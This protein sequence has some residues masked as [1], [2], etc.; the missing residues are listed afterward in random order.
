MQTLDQVLR[1]ASAF[2]V[3]KAIEECQQNL[4]RAAEQRDKEIARAKDLYSRQ[5]EEINAVLAELG[6]TKRGRPA[7][8]PTTPTGEKRRRTR[9]ESQ[10]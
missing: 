5:A 3:T 7:G 6:A 10:V 1:A 2:A 8:S 4:A 9:K